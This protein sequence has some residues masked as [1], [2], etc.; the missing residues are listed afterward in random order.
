M[1][2][3]VCDSTYSQLNFG[4]LHVNLDFHTLPSLLLINFLVVFW[5]LICRMI[6]YR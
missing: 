1:V 3:R 4:F 6:F 5:T 2:V